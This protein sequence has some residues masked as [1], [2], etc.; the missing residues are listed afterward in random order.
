MSAPGKS[1]R[2]CG[3]FAGGAAR[4]S[5]DKRFQSHKA[6]RPGPAPRKNHR[7]SLDAST[8]K[9]YFGEGFPSRNDHIR[10]NGHSPTRRYRIDLEPEQELAVAVPI[11]ALQP[12]GQ[13]W[14]LTL[15]DRSAV[16][17]DP[18]DGSN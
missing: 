6:P 18:F 3:P 2:T 17:A 16:D 15:V 12:V 4:R 14:D 13:R 8:G 1:R 7:A 10:R 11:L 5:I 9:L